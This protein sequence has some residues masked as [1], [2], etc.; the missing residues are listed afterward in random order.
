MRGLGITI[1]DIPCTDA[2]HLAV[3][4]QVVMHPSPAYGTGHIAP[5]AQS[6]ARIGA[7]S[8]QT[9]V[10]ARSFES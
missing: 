8:T 3:Y 5:A 4:L 1:F 10:F 9:Q 2:A 7:H 6:K